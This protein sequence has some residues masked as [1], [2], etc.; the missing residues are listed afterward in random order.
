[1]PYSY[2]G[3]IIISGLGKLKALP[4]EERPREKLMAQGTAS[5]S[6]LEL[7]TVILGTGCRGRGVTELAGHLL[8]AFGG[9]R[10]LAT[11]DPWEL[12]K[13]TGMGKAK[14]AQVT[15]ALALGQRANQLD[16]RQKRVVQSPADAAAVFCSDLRFLAKEHFR[17]LV[18]DVKNQ[19][20]TNELVSI[21]TLNA[22]L[23]HPREVFRPAISRAG[24]GVILAHNHPSGDPTPSREDLGLTKRLAE[25]GNLL[26]IEVL[27][28]IIIGDNTFISLREKGIL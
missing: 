13:V 20:L 28:H 9:L 5:L 24:A 21:G 18:L 11:T 3:E 23:V 25:C 15:A 2:R 6:N 4:E 16:A 7:L 10:G 8:T 1:M 14:A 12:S 19:I 22:S 26:G 27:D 17:C